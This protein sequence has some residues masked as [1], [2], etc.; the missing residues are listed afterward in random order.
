MA[1]TNTWVGYLD[2]SYQSIKDSLIS[3][4]VTS[5]PEMTDHS[6]SNILV[7]ILGMFAGLVEM[8][9]YYV[10]NMAR[11]AFV[12]TARKF[13]SMVR[14]VK[15][16]DYRIKAAYPAT[17][18]IVFT[19]NAPLTGPAVIPAGTQI[20]TSNN[21]PF[22]TV[23][24]LNLAT[25][26]TTGT[27]GAKQITHITAQNL[28]TTSGVNN[29]AFSLGQSYVDS[30]SVI[31]IDSIPWTEV[32]SLGLYGATDK[33]YVVE[34]DVDGLAYAVFGNGTNGAIPPNPKSVIA[35]FDVT[36]ANLGNVDANTITT[37][38]TTLTLPGVTTITIN[39][40]LPATAGSVYEDIERIRINAPL[41]I[42]TLDRA[43]TR[44]DYIDITRMAPGVGRADVFFECGKTV[45]IYIIPTLGG[46]A[47][48][49]LLATTTNFITLRKMITT[50]INVMAAGETELV[51]EL[52]V[53][54]KFRAPVADVL[55]DV[56]AVLM[57]YGSYDK[58]NINKKVRLSDFIAA[59]DNLSKV[60]N[61]DL[62]SIKTRPYA[63]P[64][65]HYTQLIWSRLS[66]STSAVKSEWS[67]SYAGGTSFNVV[68]DQVYL[69]VATSGVLWVDPL[70]SVQFTIQL[71]SYAI[72]DT[73]TFTIY[74]WNKN[75]EFDDFTMPKLNANDITINV[76][77]QLIPPIE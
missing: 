19:F 64:Q 45:D 56:N 4:L 12:A 44:Q 7:V 73:W 61:V 2:R 6:E 28:G 3:R 66:L 62:V 13:V 77:E 39:N 57:S 75:I 43:V 55:T 9:N 16:L 14:L 40:P 18:D 63:R 65:N 67:I 22:I 8:L 70:L 46:I 17:V 33:V 1:I 34:I 35:D 68:K 76:T 41:S 20:K 11:E 36:Q 23:T 10:D 72:G 54:A 71:A 26:A 37:L 15:L 58:Q 50:F 24:N 53:T 29:E 74:P 51:I 48:S 27:V 60:E 5:N 31:T 21:I 47:Q 30:S 25:G 49:P 38:V 59:V 42:R 69:G 32:T 52:D